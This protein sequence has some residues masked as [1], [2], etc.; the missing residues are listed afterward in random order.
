MNPGMNKT[1]AEGFLRLSKEFKKAYE[2]I[3]NEF[4]DNNHPDFSELWMVKRH[5][6]C[7]SMELALKAFII[8]KITQ[9]DID[10][11]YGDYID[12]YLKNLGHS[13]LECLK[14]AE[15]KNLKPLKEESKNIISNFDKH[16]L[17]HFKFLISDTKAI[18]YVYNKN[19]SNL[20]K[21]KLI[22]KKLVELYSSIND[23]QFVE[24]KKILDE[25]INKIEESEE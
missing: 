13:L 12:E 16:Y 4:I 19:M 20:E 5:L 2:I 14:I 7:Q 25:L 9:E 22:E 6:V 1:Y 3:N 10:K 21:N 11:L 23:P 24:L 15:G 18:N 8:S 17:N